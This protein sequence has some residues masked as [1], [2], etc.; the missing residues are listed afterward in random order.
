M[1]RTG[2]KYLKMLDL[3]WQK[4]KNKVR[5]TDYW[6]EKYATAGDND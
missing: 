6:V 3:D 2:F 5:K 4:K 1:K